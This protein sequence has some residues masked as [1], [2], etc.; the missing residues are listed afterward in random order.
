MNQL[1][2]EILVRSILADKYYF[3]TFNI[4]LALLTKYFKNFIKILFEKKSWELLYDQ[5]YPET[6]LNETKFFK[7][8]YSLKN[9]GKIIYRYLYII[10]R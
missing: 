8:I 6:L 10:Y 2:V 4:L 1:R 7:T 9:T 5:D 3:F